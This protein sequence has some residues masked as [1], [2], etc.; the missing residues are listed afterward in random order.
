MEEEKNKEVL[1]AEDA[2][3]WRRPRAGGFCGTE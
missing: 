3:G 2:A 1:T